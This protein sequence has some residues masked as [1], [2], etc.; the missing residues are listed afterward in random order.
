MNELLKWEIE[1]EMVH[2]NVAEPLQSSLIDDMTH[3]KQHYKCA[4]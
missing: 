1:K 4:S 3:Y 2:D